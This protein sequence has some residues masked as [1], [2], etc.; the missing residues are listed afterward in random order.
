MARSLVAGV[1]AL[2]RARESLRPDRILEDPYA[3]RFAETGLRVAA[4]RYGRFALP[5]LRR[6]VD[7]LQVAHCVR[8]AA[9][10]AL[11]QQALAEGCEQVVT[12][13]AGCDMR[14][15]RLQAAPDVRWIEVDQPDSAAYKARRLRGLDGKVHPQVVVHDLREPLTLTELDQGRSTTFVLEGLIHYLTLAQFEALLATMATFPRRQVLL[16]FIDPAQYFHAPRLFVQTVQWLREV[17]ALH[18]TADQLAA[19]LQRHGLCQ[20]QTW[21]IHQQIAQFAPQAAH[22]PVGVSQHVARARV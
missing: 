16:S 20:F 22:R 5:G 14:P 10:D 15:W 17:P 19:V 3:W 13:G 2:F 9:L 7:E 11:V 4:L 6:L 18:F 21:D 1:N 12:I 8:H